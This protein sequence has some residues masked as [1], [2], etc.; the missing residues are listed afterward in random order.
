MQYQRTVKLKDGRE[1]VLRNGTAADAQAVLDVFNLTHEQ[2][3]FLASYPDES[4]HT[5]ESEAAFLQKR[6]DSKNAIEI[7]AEIDGKAV[8]LAGISCFGPKSKMRHRAE[9]GV[10]IDKAYWGLGIGKALTL[11]C[12]DCAKAAGYAQLELSVVAD[13]AHAI[14]LYE[15][16]G[17]TEYGRNPMGFR[18]RETGWQE[19]IDM[20]LVLDERVNKQKDA[21]LFLHGLGG[22]ADEAAHYRP[23]FPDCEVIGL[24]YHGIEPWS[25]GEEIRN[26]VFG[27]CGEYRS[28]SLIGYSIG[29]F[30]AMHAEIDLLLK[31]AYFI[32]PVVDMESI[33]LA[34]MAQDGVTEA[35]LAEKGEIQGASG[36]TLSWAYLSYVRDHAVEWNAP[37]AILYAERDNLT[38]RETI[39]DF[40]EAHDASLTVMPDGEHWFH[41]EEQMQFL[42]DWLRKEREQNGIPTI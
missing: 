16:V 37:T 29:A 3:D 4:T 18:S 10:S 14:A 32:S 42:D 8:G 30:L 27:L 19:L 20:R 12:I 6:T 7:L 33:I 31:K 39:E 24:D 25:A 13:N 17:F 38:P 41:T 9:F 15:S 11:A 26:A 35:E 34:L 28:V 2:T 21:V 23:L 36:L 1:C 22:S 40:A 5:V